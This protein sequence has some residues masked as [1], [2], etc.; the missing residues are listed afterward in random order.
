MQTI[1][2][3]NINMYKFKL[4]ISYFIML[5]ERWRGILIIDIYKVKL[6]I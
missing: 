5:N 1:T 6:I 3:Y 2:E 4:L